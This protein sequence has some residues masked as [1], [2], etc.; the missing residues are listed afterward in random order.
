MNWELIIGSYGYIGLLVGTFL[1]G[2]TILILAGFAAHLGYLHLPWVILVAFLG[3][4]SGDQL[5]FYLGRRQSRFVLEKHPAWHRRLD[6]VERLF[7][8]YQTL[9][10]LGFRF[11]YGLRTVTPFVL[12]RS[13]VAPGY[14][15]VLNTVG[16]M[17][18]SLVVGIAGYLFGN[19]LKI[20]IGDIK[21]Y[22]LEAFGAIAIIGGLIW[23]VHFYRS[24]RK[25]FP[26]QIG[27]IEKP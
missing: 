11:L 4:L 6:R 1:E 19:I 10:I 21:R 23:G 18:W 14:F 8:R 20:I 13:G 27:S 16:A 12:G 5:F 17:V 9:L 2:E 26:E 22:E 3:T 24:R 15:F 7:E 25:K